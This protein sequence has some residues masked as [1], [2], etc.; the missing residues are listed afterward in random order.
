MYRICVHVLNINK[1]KNI[2][3]AAPSLSSFPMGK[4]LNTTQRGAAQGILVLLFLFTS[5]KKSAVVT[6]HWPNSYMLFTSL[7]EIEAYQ[8]YGIIWLC[9]INKVKKN[10]EF[11]SSKV[12]FSARMIRIEM[13]NETLFWMITIQ[14]VMCVLPKL[15][16]CLPVKKSVEAIVTA[17]HNVI[18]IS[19]Y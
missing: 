3:C 18:Y 4:K 5:T 14:M 10:I 16:D 8:W 17:H 19:A 1:R 11:A 12:K 6:W 7:N 9:T 15:I 2:P 13:K